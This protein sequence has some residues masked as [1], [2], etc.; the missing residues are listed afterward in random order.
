[1]LFDQVAVN[2]QPFETFDTRTLP[3]VTVMPGSG[4]FAST[5]M[6]DLAIAVE[7]GGLAVSDIKLFFDGADVSSLLGNLTPG[8]LAAGGVTRRLRNFP[9][10]TL[11]PGPHVVGVEVSFVGGQVARGVAL[12][13]VLPAT[14]P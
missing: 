3:R 12:W 9:L 5:Q 11:S 14:G 2:G 4:T 6:T 10:T 1:M 13:N 7:T 8:T